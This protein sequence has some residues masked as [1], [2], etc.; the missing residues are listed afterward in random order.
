MYHLTLIRY[1]SARWGFVGCVPACLAYETDDVSYLEIARRC[2][3]GLAKQIAEEEG[4]VFRCLSWDTR[5]AAIAYAD[6]H[7]VDVATID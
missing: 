5:E 6:A 7:G 2:G 3:P 1:P 4:A